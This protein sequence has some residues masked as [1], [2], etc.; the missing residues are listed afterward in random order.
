MFLFTEF[1]I[2]MSTFLILFSVWWLKPNKCKIQCKPSYTLV[3]IDNLFYYFYLLA[4][5][6]V[7]IMITDSKITSSCN[8]D[9]SFSYFCLFS[10]NSL[11]L[12]LN[13]Y[14]LRGIIYFLFIL[15]YVPI[16]V[17]L[18][19]RFFYNNWWSLILV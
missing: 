7:F 3:S 10:R 8:L 15:L 12:F 4:N 17:F 11:R 14:L 5:I 6:I 9:I 2:F 13:K 18:Y 19:I 16:V 1:N